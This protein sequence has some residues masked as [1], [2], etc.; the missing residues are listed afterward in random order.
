MAED[1]TPYTAATLAIEAATVA[2][3]KMEDAYTD[4]FDEFAAVESAYGK[5]FKT[6]N[7]TPNASDIVGL[8]K[9]Y[10]PTALKYFGA[11]GAGASVLL[12]LSK[13]G[14]GAG[15]LSRITGLFGG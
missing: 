3:D 15:I 4:A 12:A 11:G 8:V 9:K 13:D 2:R 6:L 14:T 1:I 7:V 10:G 5:F